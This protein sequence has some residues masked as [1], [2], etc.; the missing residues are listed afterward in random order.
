L[1]LKENGM[2]WRSPYP[3]VVIPNIS[4][5]ECILQ[6]AQRM[7]DKAALIEGLTGQVLTYNQLIE[8]V[9][10]VAASLASR[11]LT[12]GDVVAIYSPNVPAYAVVLYAVALLGGISTTVNPLYT[13]DELAT[14]LTDARAQYLVTIP[15][16]M[17]RA[18]VAAGRC[19]LR[20]LFVF[21][22]AAPAASFT[23]LL[24]GNGSPPAV[25]IDP[26]NDLAVLPYS[27]G[28]T[29]VNKGVMLTHRNLVANLTQLEPLGIVREDDMLLGLLPFYHIYG[30]VC[31]VHSGLYMGCTVVTLPRFDLEQFLDTLQQYRITATHLVPPIILALAK[32][33]LVERY[34]LSSL[35][36]VFSGAA[37]LGQELAQACED[38]VGCVIHQ[39]FGMTETSPVTHFN[40]RTGAP[41][42]SVGQCIPNTECKV[43]APAG[44]ELGPG[45]LGELAVRGPQI[46]KGY[47]NNPVATAHTIDGEG[48]L[49]TGDLGYADDTGNFFIVDRLK[50][51]IKYKGYQVAPA[52]LEAVLLT[53]PMVADVAVIRSPDEEAGEVPKAFVVL[54]GPM[55]LDDI[56]SYVGERVAPHKRIR[57]IE[58]VDQIPKAASGKILR[59]VLME[60]ELQTPTATG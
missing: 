21:G 54:K 5:A 52:E 30:M 56:V 19:S 25:A 29:G 48:W 10:S 13:T 4:L 49:Y 38:R 58:V 24:E 9:Q 37:P 2:I 6:R 34:D 31:I 27:S 59:R 40:M 45:E 26:P 47:L 39:G 12:K 32:H 16:L 43:C 42:G 36:V 33:P 46:M 51:L 50:E 60:R 8:Q 18:A 23:S 7:G 53:H 3:D 17:E 20:E 15:A 11:G 28:T 14:Q 44:D 1:L 57:R 55:P 35:R 41:V 22:D